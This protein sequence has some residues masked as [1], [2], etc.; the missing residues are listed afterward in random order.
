MPSGRTRQPSYHPERPTLTYS[1]MALDN[2]VTFPGKD[3]QGFQLGVNQG[4]I[5]D[6]VFNFEK[7]NDK[8]LNDL[9]LT[10]PRDDKERIKNTKGGLLEGSYKWILDHSYFQ[11]WRN[12][13]H[14]RLLWI[15]GDPG[16]G[17]TMLLIGIVD[18][19]ERQL[20]QLKQAQQSTSPTVLSYFFCQ[21]TD[22]NLNNVTAVLRG[23]IYLLAVQQPSLTSNLREEYEHSSSKLFE[24]TN[25][26]VALSK[27]LIGM[28]RDPTLAMAYIIIDALDECETGLQQLLKL[29]IE[30]TSASHVK[31]I[32]SSRNRYDIEQQL[33]LEYSQ[34]NLSL[35]LEANTEYV[36]HAVGVYIDDR[37]SHLKSLQD[38]DGPRDQVRHILRQKAADTFLWVAL[39]VQELRTVPS[40]DVLDVLEEIPTGLEELYDRMMKQIQQLKR[41]NPEF[42]RLMLS[43][44][45][46]AYRPLH[47]LE[48]GV[49]TGLPEKI[50]N[51]AQT[52][53]ELVSMCGSFL[54]VRDDRVYIIH[55]SVKDYLMSEMV[56]ATIFPTGIAE[57]HR[58]IYLRS[59]HAMR[60]TLRRDIYG[61]RHHGFLI[62]DLKT[63]VPDPMASVQYS[64]VHWVDHLCEV[65]QRN[66]LVDGGPVHKFLEGCLLY[67]AEASSLLGALPDAVL[68]VGNLE[69]L[70]KVSVAPQQKSANIPTYYRLSQTSLAY[71]PWY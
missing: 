62:D 53:R 54:T 41:G 63:P 29:V 33:K 49:L 7:T 37:V 14:S 56:I 57:A 17:K 34:T 6:I 11:R 67:W 35:Q 25:A 24:D 46:L 13:D 59:L 40:W 55:Q 28:L 27:I 26:F 58:N 50:S 61:L 3:N 68:A 39:V 47:M 42:C 5:G 70:L 69:R 16:K 12:D 4:T 48:L 31:W 44:A 1:R 32:V 60:K 18:E 19:L 43:T 51:K 9:R 15:K 20:A 21:G 2:T 52:L 38:D 30:N 8:C 64:C 36:S 10:N 45:T 66:D 23:L 65:P 22:S 71:S